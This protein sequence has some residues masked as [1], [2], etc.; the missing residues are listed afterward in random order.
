M[1][2]KE[3]TRPGLTKNTVS[4]GN[5]KNR[6]GFK[7][8]LYRLAYKMQKNM[9]IRPQQSLKQENRHLFDSQHLLKKF[10]RNNQKKQFHIFSK[11]SLYDSE[12][13][14]DHTGRQSY[15]RNKS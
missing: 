7:I 5:A 15:K 10:M 1:P 11:T 9:Q 8:T 2:S 12:R 13:V 6:F 3:Q 14:F 4:E